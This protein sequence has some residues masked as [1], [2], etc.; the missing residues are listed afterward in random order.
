MLNENLI[1]HHS[2]NNCS[3]FPT[4][5]NPILYAFLSDNFKKSFMKAFTCAKPNEIN[6]QLHGENS[7]FPRFGRGGRNSECFSKAPTTH[8]T[9]HNH[10]T[11]KLTNSTKFGNT[12]ESILDATT[13]NGH[14]NG[15]HPTNGHHNGKDDGALLNIPSPQHN[16]ETASVNDDSCYEYEDDDDEHELKEHITEN[17]QTSAMLLKR[18][19][20]KPPVLHTDL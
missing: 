15:H 3:N 20:S 2:L 18:S 6:A 17:E 11:S 9:T 13:N 16:H 5:M 1:M 10:I 19:T 12:V 8:I 14:E 7:F 4:A